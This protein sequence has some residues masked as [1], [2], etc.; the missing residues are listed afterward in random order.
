MYARQALK[1]SPRIAGRPHCVS[2]RTKPLAFM[3]DGASGDITAA[4]I[5]A[6]GIGA[7]SEFDRLAARGIDVRGKIVLVRH[8]VGPPIVVTSPTS[9]SNAAPPRC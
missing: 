2:V 9:R 1:W 6:A 4:V 7:P 5:A 8:A 3:V